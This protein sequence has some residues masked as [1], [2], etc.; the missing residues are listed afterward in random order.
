MKKNK[1]FNFRFVTQWS[2]VSGLVGDVLSLSESDW[3]Y[4]TFRQKTIVGH[5]Y[6]K[7]IPLIFDSRRLKNE[8]VTHKHFAKFEHH[9][10]ALSSELK[11]LGEDHQILRANLVLLQATK[12]IDSHIDKGDFLLG[13]RRLHIPITTN[14]ECFFIVSEERQKMCVGEIWEINNTGKIHSVHNAGSTD[15]THLIIDVK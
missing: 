9:L 15:R 14:S 7:T 5:R 10:S 3:D 11:V 8:R 12:S 4:F 1:D 6:T 13:T 2:G